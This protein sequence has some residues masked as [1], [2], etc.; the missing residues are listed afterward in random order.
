MT[1]GPAV[2]RALRGGGVVLLPCP[3]GYVLATCSASGVGRVFA[4]KGRAAEKPL[5]VAGSAEREGRDFLA[6]LAGRPAGDLRGLTATMGLVGRR[7]EGGPA[8]PPGVGTTAD[9]AVFVGLG[10]ALAAVVDAMAEVGASVW[11][12]SA[13]RSGAG[14][15]TRAAALPAAL[16]DGV[17]AAQVE[18]SI[19]RT[20]LTGAAPTPSPIFLVDPPFSCVRDG[21][22]RA[23]A[24]GQ[25]RAAGVLPERP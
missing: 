2:L 1:A 4:L 23:S 18:D 3:V 20:A 6:A 10:P 14:N 21:W 12:T 19:V 5:S 7:R 15:T 13:N 17:D 22:G 11:V 8:T 24:E 16:R 25:L 9:I